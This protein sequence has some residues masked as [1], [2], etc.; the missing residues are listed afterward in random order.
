[1]RVGFEEKQAEGFTNLRWRG[2]AL[3]KFDNRNWIKSQTGAPERFAKT[4][5]GF[6]I[7]DYPIENKNLLK[8]TVYLEPLET[9]VLFT[10]ARP[11][12]ISRGNFAE[13][14]KDSEDS[15]KVNRTGFERTAYT[16]ISDVSMPA[17]DK[18]KTDNTAYSPEFS[19]YLQLP[20]ELD[21]RI[22]ELSRQITDGKT[23]RFDK[24]KAIETHLQN[25]FGYT[26]ELKAGGEQPL[27]DFLFNVREGHCEYFSTAMAVMLR[28]Q[29]IAAR[30]VNGFQTGEYNE[31]AGVYVVRQKDAHSWVEVYFPKENAWIPFDPTP[32][33]GQRNSVAASTGILG[34]FNNYLVALETLWIQYFVAFDNHEQRSLFR[35]VKSG[36]AEYQSKSSYWLNNFQNK[37]SVWWKR[38]SRRQR[39]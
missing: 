23:N 12:V 38:S 21:R 15:I 33:A 29:G 16:V 17:A 9:S 34:N 18:L 19:R 30:V 7:I 1:M 11:V 2:V 27:A 8:Y 10:L 25:N 28:T 6:Y 35:S 22:V 5:S 26:L 39:F 24:A 36:F 20:V 13:L 31:T 3:D 14:R 4:E 37:I 32:F